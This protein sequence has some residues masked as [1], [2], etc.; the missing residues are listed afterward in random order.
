MTDFREE[1]Q[2]H[3]EFIKKV[4]SHTNIPMT[5]REEFFYVEAMVH[6]YKHGIQSKEKVTKNESTNK[7]SP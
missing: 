1:A 2:K 4:C 7:A 3:L 6:G 5:M